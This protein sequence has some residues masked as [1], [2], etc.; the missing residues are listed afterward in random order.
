MSDNGSPRV[1]TL[2][3]R[4][5]AAERENAAT[6]GK[7]IKSQAAYSMTGSPR[8]LTNHVNRASSSSNKDQHQSATTTSAAVVP[9]LNLGAAR[10][11]AAVAARAW[12]TET[13]KDIIS[14]GSLQI[15]SQPQHGATGKKVILEKC[16]PSSSDKTDHD[17]P[18]Q[19][20]MSE[21]QAWHGAFTS[22]IKNHA[23]QGGG[24]GKEKRPLDG[25]S[26]S[27]TKD[28]SSNSKS[29][30]NKL[31]KNQHCVYTKA[32]VLRILQ[33]CIV[34]DSEL[35]MDSRV[36]GS[37]Q[38]IFVN[39]TRLQEVV[40]ENFEH[41]FKKATFLVKKVRDPGLTALATGGADT[42]IEVLMKNVNWVKERA[43]PA[44]HGEPFVQQL[45][46]E[47]VARDG[48]F[49]MQ[50]IPGY[51]SRRSP[52]PKSPRRHGSKKA[53]DAMAKDK[54]KLP[55]LNVSGG[56]GTHNWWAI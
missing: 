35:D 28:T 24:K 42:A 21:Q 20:L 55:Q 11:D 12:H 40:L 9:K 16:G 50:P 6:F 15:Q 37:S 10:G 54:L 7:K 29:R 26:S 34:K 17:G 31:D 47:R 30:V 53:L 2:K 23:D 13:E 49:L 45:V 4:I 3:E 33:D 48:T 22:S 8:V 25:K 52:R 32:D 41:R 36:A 56:N 39:F 51:S 43:A 1:P 44:L 18:K 27:S 19:V 46:E 38:E 14:S 5:A